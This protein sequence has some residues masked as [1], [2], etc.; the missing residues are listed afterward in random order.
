[1]YDMIAKA[2]NNWE[3]AEKYTDFVKCAALFA[4]TGGWSGAH[5]EAVARG[6]PERIVSQL[7]AAVSAATTGN[8]GTTTYG[9]SFGA[10]IA[11]MFNIGA[12][13]QIAA[14]ALRLPNQFYGRFVIG[15]GVTVAA[16]AEAAGIPVRT[17]TF[18]PTKPNQCSGRHHQRTH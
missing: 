18:S 4:R 11:S 13:E 5:D 17:V 16:V 12:A 2:R 8:V 14:A 9:P 3:Q 1:M 6:M 7:K 10:F 15:G